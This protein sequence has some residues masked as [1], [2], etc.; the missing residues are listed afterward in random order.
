[1]QQADFPM[2]RVDFDELELDYGDGD[3][4]LRYGQPFTGAAYGLRPDGSL[5]DEIEYANG[6]RH[7]KTREWYPSGQLKAETTYYKGA[8]FGPD[9]EWDENGHLRSET[10]YEYSYPVRERKWD[11]N[12][13]LISETVLGPGSPK[14]SR[15]QAL[16]ETYDK[17]LSINKE[18]WLSQ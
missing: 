9:R 1:M 11:E 6:E 16:R 18:E 13:Q 8:Y 10:I 12:G 15:L 17:S 4:Y 3:R 14:Y 2:P 7:G 5:W